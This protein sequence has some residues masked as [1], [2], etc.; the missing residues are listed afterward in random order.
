MRHM[1]RNTVHIV[2]DSKSTQHR[3][4][5][6]A[7]R[8]CRFNKPYCQ[9]CN[10]DDLEH[11]QLR[12]RFVAIIE[13]ADVFLPIIIS[14]EDAEAFLPALPPLSASTNPND[15]KKLQIRIKEASEKVDQTLLGSRM[16]GERVRPVIDWSLETY[17]IKAN[18][19]SDEAYVVARAFGMMSKSRPF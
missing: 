12:Y 16:N 7:K 9:S 4:D 19:K 1:C 17:S 18:A 8:A 10:D 2:I 6:E 14:D 3:S 5:S 13:Q 11:A 15:G